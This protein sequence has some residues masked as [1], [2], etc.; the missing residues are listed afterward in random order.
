[1][2]AL[3]WPVVM[4]VLGSTMYQMENLTN[5]NQLVGLNSFWIFALPLKLEAEASQVRA[6]AVMEGV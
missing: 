1:M 4:A 2:F 3:I 6:V 5:L